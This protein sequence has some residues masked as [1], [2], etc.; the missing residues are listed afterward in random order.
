MCFPYLLDLF[1]SWI[2]RALVM[3]SVHMGVCCD[4]CCEENIRGLRQACLV[5]EDYDLCE[6]CFQNKR[7]NNDHL[8]YHPT[9]P[10]LPFD[11]FI[12]TLHPLTADE[13]RVFRCP[14]CGDKEFNIKELLEHCRKYHEAG[15]HR[16]RCPI[17]VTYG[18]KN[19]QNRLLEGTLANHLVNDHVE[20][21]IGELASEISQC[22]I[23]IDDM[24]LDA[25]SCRPLLCG[26]HFHIRCIVRWLRRSMNC[27]VCRA[28]VELPLG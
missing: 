27:P 11:E 26:H 6:K 14:Y 19:K 20:V 10:I 24:N 21:E 1:L 9:Q 8:P 25:P 18:I 17:C 23:C 3:S 4:V 2:P 15:S 28:P 7:F 5:C 16:V 13:I 22:P 12:E